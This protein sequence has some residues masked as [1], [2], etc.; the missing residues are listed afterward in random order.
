MEETI[1]K[2]NIKTDLSETGSKDVNWIE[3][4]QIRTMVLT[5][6]LPIQK[7]KLKNNCNSYYSC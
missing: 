1:H 7:P 2:D 3:M 4:A 5:L 6:I